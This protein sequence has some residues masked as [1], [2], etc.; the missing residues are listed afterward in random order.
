MTLLFRTIVYKIEYFRYYCR[1]YLFQVLGCHVYN[2]ICK[3]I[4]EYTKECHNHGAR[5]TEKKTEQ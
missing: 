3:N 5:G 1:K 2:F 4:S